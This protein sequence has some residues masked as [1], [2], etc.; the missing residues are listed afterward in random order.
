MPAPAPLMPHIDFA[1]DEVLNLHEVLDEL[2]DQGPVVPVKFHGDPVWL[3]LDHA[4]LDRAFN[5]NVCFDPAGGYLAMTEIPMGR[6]LLALNGEEHSANRAMVAASFLPAKVRSYVEALI[7]P[8]VH[9]LLDRIQDER[10]VDFVSAFARPFPFTVITRLL[11]IP[12]SDERLFME[13]AVKLIDYPWDPEGALKAKVGFD[14]YMEGIIE[15]RRRNPGDDFVSMLTRAEFEGERLDNERILAL[16]RLLF[17]AGSDTTYKNGGSLF[18]AVLADDELRALAMRGDAERANIVTEGLRWQPPTALL[19]RMASGDVELGGAAISK[20]DW[21]LFGITA[22]NSD[23]KLFPDPR[24]FDPSRDNRQMITFGRGVHFCLGMHLARRELEAALK[25]VLE[26]FPDI[27]LTPGK[28]VEFVSA[29][30]RGP[31]DLWVQLHGA[32]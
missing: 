4:E 15:T 12:V 9:E 2:R 16:F 8:V 22:A 28:P 20:G 1:Y 18:A 29:V 19:P 7:E 10:E 26:R 31:R 23:P 30:L 32:P 17:P 14:N 24:R 13:W 11:G 6:N 5:D 25:I 3:I 21:T 27:R